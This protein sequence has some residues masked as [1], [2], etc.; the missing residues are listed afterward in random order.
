[1]IN[2]HRILPD[3]VGPE[4]YARLMA[5]P[6]V[7]ELEA[8]LI[9]LRRSFTFLNLA[10]FLRA[11]T[12]RQPLAPYSLMLTFDDGYRDIHERL[13]PLLN[14]LE[15]PATIFI[16]TAPMN[17]EALWFQQLFA[18]VIGS[19]LRESPPGLG[20]AP[21]PMTTMSQRVQTITAFAN[22]HIQV[23]PEEWSAQL[24]RICDAFQWD[25]DLGDE[26]MMTWRELESVRR[27]PWITIG[28]HTVS[29]PFLPRCDDRRLAAELV[30]CAHEL[31]QR[32][33][34]ATLPFAYPNGGSDQ[35]VVDA[36]ARAGYDCSF[37]MTP[38][39]NTPRTD[40]HKLYRH[41]VDP[42]VVSASFDL[43]FR[44]PMGEEC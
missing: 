17:G 6:T 2:F 35:R 30:D 26:R 29:H 38:G 20:V 12:G 8:L 41:Y 43:S 24:P 42:D 28:G 19:P 14:R 25:G 37:L 22:M 4:Y 13:V 11:V 15:L 27:C 9:Y 23:S 31:R 3:T 44:L 36:V 21:M 7:A 5:E 39:L 18:A 1:V 16:N 32:L 10:E 33:D 34:L 40:R